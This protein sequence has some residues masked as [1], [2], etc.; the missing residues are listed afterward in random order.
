MVVRRKW[1]LYESISHP[2]TR[3]MPAIFSSL[4][5]DRESLVSNWHVAS[6]SI[7]NN[8]VPASENIPMVPKT[9]A[10]QKRSLSILAR[11]SSAYDVYSNIQGQNLTEKKRRGTAVFRILK[12]LGSTVTILN[13]TVVDDQIN[14]DVFCPMFQKI[15]S[16]AEDVAEIDS[17]STE[18]KPTYCID[19][20]IIGTLFKVSFLAILSPFLNPLGGSLQRS[21]RKGPLNLTS[22]R[23]S[24]TAETLSSA[25]K[26][27]QYFVHAI[28]W[29]EHGIVL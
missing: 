9:G 23:S 8:W 22:S 15:T 20:A 4:S 21:S 5:K 7:G 11:W 13:R 29:K 6:Y 1:E 16:L 14:W 25:E 28:E 19:M 24:V 26:Q 17:K 10:W 3:G 18:V 12:E 27:S 2:P